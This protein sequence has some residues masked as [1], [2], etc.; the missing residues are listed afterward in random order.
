MDETHYTKVTNWR[1]RHFTP[2]EIASKSDGLIKIDSHSMD[3]LQK[4]RE[5]VQV[6][7]IIN[8]GYRS[9]AHN[10]LVGG[11]PNSQ[12][13]LGKAFDI[14]ITDALSREKI[15]FHAKEAGFTGIGDYQNFVHL[16]TGPARYWDNR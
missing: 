13:L 7:V 1:W 14:R 6:P 10:K 9:K 8:S 5:L 12:H 3:C 11:A 16:D 2:K 15:K 4:F